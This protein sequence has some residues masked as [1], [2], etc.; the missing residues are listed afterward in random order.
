MGHSAALYYDRIQIVPVK[1]DAIR[2]GVFWPTWLDVSVRRYLENVTTVLEE[3]G[4]NVV[5]FKTE[6]APP[7]DC[8]VYWDPRL[9]GGTQPWHRLFNVDAPIIATVHGASPLTVPP[10]EYYPNL[11]SAM[12]GFLGVTKRLVF[13]RRWANRLSAIITTSESAKREIRRR[14]FL[15]GQEISVIHHGV[16]HEVFYPDEAKKNSQDSQYFLHASAYQ[17]IK[18]TKR[19][20]E[21]FARV[22]ESQPDLRLVAVLPNLPETFDIPSGVE[23]TRDEISHAQLADLYRG[24][25]GF[26][27]PSLTESFGMPIVEAMAC[28]CPVITSTSGACPEVAGEAAIFV[29]PRSVKEIARAMTAVATDHELRHKLEV[30]ASARSRDF[31]WKKAGEQHMEVFRSS[32]ARQRSASQ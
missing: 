3:M 14:F 22:R 2:V 5:A 16:D 23:L 10:W 4:S 18:N 17:P 26:V 11:R 8:D 9:T 6:D 29:D 12:D 7:P 25:L 31:S 13:W 15:S 27:F 30:A 21:A 32:L 1:K 24:A 28:K 20:F 19:V